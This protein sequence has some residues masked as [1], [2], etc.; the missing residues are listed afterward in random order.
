MNI[1]PADLARSSVLPSPNANDLQHEVQVTVRDKAAYKVSK[2][3]LPPHLPA[4]TILPAHP[5]DINHRA[6][7][8]SKRYI[9]AQSRVRE[10]SNS[11]RI[12]VQGLEDVTGD[13]SLI[14]ARNSLES[15]STS[16]GQDLDAAGI[17]LAVAQEQRAITTTPGTED[18][19]VAIVDEP[20]ESY[21]F[22]SSWICP[23]STCT[24][25][26]KRFSS[27]LEWGRHT[28]THF[29]GMGC[30]HSDCHWSISTFKDLDCLVAHT[31]LG[32]RLASEDTGKHFKCQSCFYNLSQSDYLDHLDDCIVHMVEREASGKARPCPV[33]SCDHHL[34]DFPSKY[35]R[36]LHLLECHMVAWMRHY[37]YGLQAVSQM[38]RTRQSIYAPHCREPR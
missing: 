33:S 15:Q 29:E 9:A 32:H 30:G 37:R 11:V 34:T 14:P 10:T 16:E 26:H 27:K 18:M 17:L 4:I 1:A 31:K 12:D 36:G 8:Q 20:E 13:V 2:T 5:I 35:H 38:V 7:A 3:A 6:L 28:R 22:N 19:S 21:I 25:H 24:D 23:V